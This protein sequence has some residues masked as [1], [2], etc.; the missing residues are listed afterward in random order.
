MRLNKIFE[1]LNTVTEL[2]IKHRH[3][4]QLDAIREGLRA[5]RFD[6]QAHINYKPTVF[7]RVRRWFDFSKREY[8]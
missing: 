4:G 3:D 7:Q 5:V 8:T 2:A 6:L 1:E